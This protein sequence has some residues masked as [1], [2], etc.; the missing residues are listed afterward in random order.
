MTDS[1]FPNRL[2]DARVVYEGTNGLS[3]ND[4][5]ELTGLPRRALTVQS[6]SEGWAKKV[7]EGQSPEAAAAVAR[8]A[9][10]RELVER[11]T[12]SPAVEDSTAA[13][14]TQPLQ[15]DALGSLLERHRK[16]WS[17]MRALAG[18]AVRLRDT[19]PIRSFER[20]KLAKILTEQMDIV[21]KGERRAWGVDEKDLP[22][23]NVLF[24]ERS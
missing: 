12:S 10:W 21:Q 13:Q 9:E 23:G 24:I 2:A 18:E 17:A 20:A 14:I 4:L 11:A 22:P 3:M 8:F 6:R 16:E 19:D 1:D 7:K 5:A 15:E